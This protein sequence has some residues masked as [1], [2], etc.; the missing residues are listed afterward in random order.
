MSP[1]IYSRTSGRRFVVLL[2][3][4]LMG[5][6]VAAPWGAVEIVFNA[7]CCFARSFL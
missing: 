3:V 2:L 7:F 4:V 5:L 6:P 1:I